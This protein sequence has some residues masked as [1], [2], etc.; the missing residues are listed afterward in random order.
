MMLEGVMLAFRAMTAAAVCS[1]YEIGLDLLLV[2][3]LCSSRSFPFHQ[4]LLPLFLAFLVSLAEPLVWR[5]CS[6]K[7]SETPF[8]E[9]NFDARV[10]TFHDD[11]RSISLSASSVFSSSCFC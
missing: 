1:Y 4:Q 5:C 2:S 6:S 10:L 9:A 7:H 3:L 11:Q 8:G